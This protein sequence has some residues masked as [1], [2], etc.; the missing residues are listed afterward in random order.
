MK[1]GSK[2][3]RGKE[4]LAKLLAAENI[5][6]IFS[7]Q[8]SAKFDLERRILYVPLME[9]MDGE[10]ANLVI[11][12]EVGHALFT[13]LDIIIKIIGDSRNKQRPID[14]DPFY[15]IVPYDVPGWQRYSKDIWNVIEDATIERKQKV[16]YP[17][18]KEI[19]ANG[20]RRLFSTEFDF[21]GVHKRHTN[22]NNLPLI[23]KLNLLAKVGA[24]STVKLEGEE[25]KLFNRM[26]KVETA[27]QLVKLGRDIWE[28]MERHKQEQKQNQKKPQPEEGNKEQNG[29]GQSETDESEEQ[30]ENQTD[31]PQEEQ[32]ENEN[33][34]ETDKIEGDKEEEKDGAEPAKPGETQE[35]FD[36]NLKNALKTSTYV[37]YHE[38]PKVI[39]PL[40]AVIGWTKFLRDLKEYQTNVLKITNPNTDAYSKFYKENS[41]IVSKMAA[42]FN[43][44]RNASNL[45]KQ[46]FAKTGVLDMDSLTMHK[47][48]DDIFQRVSVMPLEQNHGLS[49]LVDWSGSMRDAVRQTIEQILTLT[50]F[51]RLV[52]IPYSVYL[53]TD[54]KVGNKAIENN[55]IYVMS[56]GGSESVARFVPDAHMRLTN[57]LSSEMDNAAFMRI[58]NALLNIHEYPLKTRSIEMPYLQMGGTPLL[59][60]M[61][62]NSY[63]IADMKKKH[64]LAKM[65]QIIITDGNPT[66]L[67]MDNN[68]SSTSHTF[69][70]DG[71]T[72]KI[73]KFYNTSLSNLFDEFSET[74][75]SDKETPSSSV[76]AFAKMSKDRT[77]VSNYGF[78]IMPAAV[79]ENMEIIRNSVEFGGKQSSGGLMG[80]HFWPEFLRYNRDAITDPIKTLEKVMYE[81]LV[82]NRYLT[83]S[84]NAFDK[85]YAVLQIS[86]S[87]EQ[88]RKNVMNILERKINPK[89]GDGFRARE[90]A[91]QFNILMKSQE[92]KTVYCLDFIKAFA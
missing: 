84:N 30:Q 22:V 46:R 16:K 72:R 31:Q 76:M 55:L 9:G 61:L 18:S 52:K 60:A 26:M 53:F 50:M 44:R 23:D 5:T 75:L 14:P 12:H 70:I 20:Y 15:K 45:A 88:Q 66:D 65:H 77:D 56:E 17:G 36:K 54:N 25:L 74:L 41:K 63:L 21:F 57:V 38:V 6:V 81:R 7:S 49:I 40:K 87:Y 11:L 58:A 4:M 42:M 62:Y 90:A 86:T 39:D 13:E 80:S 33:Q 73:Y 48:K 29:G 47:F 82:Q 92:L 91:K 59:S 71:E 78:Y 3:L 27:D 24:F 85:F 2:A 8:T 1:M 64:H 43:M 83:F 10:I 69:L 35:E 67:Y 89:S 79:N 32:E 19:F 34:S 68:R 51:C 28:Y 37:K